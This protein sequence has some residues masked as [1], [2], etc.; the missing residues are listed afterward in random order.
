MISGAG[1]EGGRGGIRSLRKGEG[2]FVSSWKSSPISSFKCS[3]GHLLKAVGTILKV[4]GDDVKKRYDRAMKTRPDAWKSVFIYDEETASFEYSSVHPFKP[5]RAKLTMDLCRRY[6]LIERPWIRVVKPQPLS[7]EAIAKFHDSSYLKFLQEID[8]QSPAGH[9]RPDALFD[10]EGDSS[11]LGLKVLE[12]G[13]GTP[14]NPIFPGLYDFSVKTAGATFLAV[15][16][17]TSGE[18]NLAFN[19]LGGFHHA[20]RGHAE[21]FCYINDVAVAITDLLK[22]GRRIAFVDIDAHHANGVQDAFYQEDR[23]LV[24]SFHESGKNLYPWSGFEN[25]IGEGKGKGYNVNIPMPQMTDDSAFARAFHEI[26][27]PLLGAYKPDLLMTELGADTLVHDPLTDLGMTNFSYCQA[28]EELSDLALPTVALGGG[29]YDVFKT[30]RSWTLAWA[31][32]N[33]L[34]PRDEYAGIIGGMMFGPE[35]EA[36]SL[37]DKPIFATGALKDRI[38]REL[39]RVLE[40][41]KKVVFPLH[42]L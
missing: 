32:L 18:A 40:Y 23:V 27:P 31:I 37:Q 20:G 26:V 8:S 7:F 1:G 21:G 12:Y 25:E 35:N 42:G 28:V 10:Q 9:L 2:Y 19:P 38:N 16:M 6:D 30:A 4:L 36:G 41:I 29:G 11:G 15:Q 22:T 39:D 17:V 13:L 33:G 14:D 3:K 34:E 24:I 5:I